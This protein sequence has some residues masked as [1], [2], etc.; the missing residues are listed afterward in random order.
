MAILFYI[1]ALI[2][3]VST[4]MALTRTKAVQA[5][6]YLVVALLSVA[7]IFYVSGAPFIA[8]LEAIIYA[9][10][11]M[12]LFIFVVMMLNLGQDSERQ[13]RAWLAPSIWIGPSLLS[14]ILLIEF[15]IVFSTINENIDPVRIAPSQ[16]GTA[17]FTQYL[18]GVQLAGIMLM[19][20]VIGA[21]HLG[22][23]KQ[24]VVHRYLEKIEKNPES[25]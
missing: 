5:L 23:K 12:T 17:L 24:K 19:A 2:A 25:V 18:L 16:V 7:V 9:G 14:L 20:A 22:K 1:A 6:L 3:I 11:I 10:A 15:A 21:Y 8:A 13:E 4:A